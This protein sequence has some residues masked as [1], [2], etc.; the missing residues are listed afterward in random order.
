MKQNANWIFLFIFAIIS[1]VGFAQNQEVTGTV[2]DNTGLPLPGV[3]VIEEGTANGT[4]TNFDGEYSIQVGEAAVLVF[5]YLGMK[6]QRIPV[7]NRASIDVTLKPATGQ[8]DE[9]VVTALGI[10]REKKSLGYA[11]QQ[12]DGNEVSD[13][14]TQNFTNA[15]SGK[16]AGL[17]VKSSGTMG[18]STNVVIRGNASLTG[19]NQA[20]FVVDGT[21]IINQNTNTAGQ[22]AGRGGYDY[23]NAAADI[24]PDDIK[25]INVLRGAAASALY[26]ERAANGVIIIETKRGQKNKGIGVSIRSSVMFSNADE[27]TLPNYQ[28]KYGA[29]YGPYYQSDDGYF[30]LYD[31]NGDG[32]LDETTPFTEDASFGAAFDPDRMIYQWNSIYPGLDTYQQASPWDAAEHTPN[33][34]WETGYTM[35]NSVALD[36]GTDKSTYRIGFTNLDQEG[37]LPNSS[38]TRNNINLSATHDFTDKFK[39]A[40]NFNFIKTDGKG[41]YGTGYDAL[42]IMQSFR[43]WNQANVDLYKQRD[44]YF[45]TGRNITWNP[46]GP[47]NLSPIYTD[48]PYFTRYEN[49]Q[50]DTRNRYFGNINLT[51]Q[52]NDV[53]SL[54]GRFTF[55]TYSELQEERKNVGSVGVS[56]YSR[57]NN[58]VAEYNYDLILNFNKNL[59]DDLNLD[60]N[61]GFNLRRNE[62]TFIRAATNGGLFETGLYAL[63]NSRNPINPPI[64]YEADQMVDGLF[65]RAS[66]GY[67]NTYFLE[68][69]VRRDRS[70][71]LPQSDNTYIYPSV[72]TSVL[73]SNIIDQDWLNFA[74]FRANYAQVGSATEPYNVFNTYNMTTPFDGQGIA[75][76]PSTLNNLNLKSETSKSYEVGLEGSFLDNRLNLDFSYYRTRTED[77]ITPVPIS[78]ASG[79]LRKLL[80]AGEIENKGIEVLLSGTPVKLDDFS[81]NVSM[82]WSRNRNEVISL[83]KG[84]ENLQLASLQGGVSINAAPGEPYG[85]IRGSDYVYDESGN[86]I[87]NSSGYYET[88][89]SNNNIIGNIQPDW[90]AG[91]TNTLTYKNFRFSFL[92]DIQQGGDIFS[93]DTWYGMATGVYDVTA[94]IN[95]LGNEMRAPLTNGPDSG[96]IILPGV[97]AD[98]AQNETRVPFDTYANPYGYA[99]DANKGHVYDASFIKL[100]EMSLTYDFGPEALDK[101]PF[102]NASLSLIGR[103]LWIIDKNLPY[104]DPEAGLSSGNIQGYQSGAY[105]A[106]KQYG[107]N[108]KF[109]F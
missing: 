7:N 42:N 36:G 37:S 30:N 98:G 86:K 70:S 72:S 8:L 97:N 16:V 10:K 100:R 80:N 68:A 64:E 82:N 105:P 60:G 53:F 28:Q 54:L 38:I 93:L 107:V 56:G 35:I 59:T 27:K 49:Y 9:V 17:K 99:R 61:L 45:A 67:L 109:N 4:Q 85:A 90:N 32:T 101:L 15:L 43:Q 23:G 66:L 3:N 77:Q 24:N 46:N 19:S 73:L 94:G 63:S 29:G 14:A 69:T 87:V 40:S 81:W 78:N 34:I 104:S 92:L 52:I 58:R 84:I 83:T 103:N 75:S 12:V 39:V 5:S 11:T 74:K 47:D 79:Y 102:T 48:N 88:T 22:R 21:P 20:L 57:F 65:A 91:I 71:T 44:A 1:Q 106:M 25:S 62:Q 2:V 55:D 13:V 51:Y 33:D 108:L 50:T 41:R 89:S 76:N 95:D 18:G 6:E 31:V 26:G 96:G